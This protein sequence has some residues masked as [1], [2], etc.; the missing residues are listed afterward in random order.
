MRTLIKRLKLAYHLLKTK[1]FIFIFISDNK[2]ATEPMVWRSHGLKL[3]EIPIFFSIVETDIED[4][5]REYASIELSERIG[6]ELIR[7]TKLN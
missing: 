4:M 1:R 5:K 3:E 6:D 7:M 2:D